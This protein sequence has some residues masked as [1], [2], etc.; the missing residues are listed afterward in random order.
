[1]SFITSMVLLSALIF[2]PGLD[3]GKIDD[4]NFF[5]CGF[6]GYGMSAFELEDAVGNLEQ[7]SYIPGGLQF[8]YSINQSFR[9][10]AEVETCLSP[11]TCE[12]AD[13]P[14][15]L[16]ISMGTI[17]LVAEF[18]PTEQFFIRGGVASYSG[19]GEYYDDYYGSTGRGDVE[20]G[21]GFNVGAGYITNISGNFYGGVEGVYHIVSLQLD[22]DFDTNTYDFNHWAARAFVGIAF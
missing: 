8:L 21:I 17:G 3:A 15:E 2:K 4:L 5:L 6:I 19:S 14:N 7:G 12:D 1:M 22:D 10:G 18:L 13:N 9:V 16:E 11:F 20:S